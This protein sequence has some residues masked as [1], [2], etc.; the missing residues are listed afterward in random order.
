MTE[1][2]TRGDTV[3]LVIDGVSVLTAT[4]TEDYDGGKRAYLDR[5]PN[6]NLTVELWETLG[7]QLVKKNS[8]KTGTRV[9]LM[10]NGTAVKFDTVINSIKND[11]KVTVCLGSHPSLYLTES[12]WKLM[13]WRK[14]RAL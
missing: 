9:K 4:V 1:T 7:W 10:V 11:N 6:A 3:E 8:W 14:R 12:E 5:Y 2:W 13:G